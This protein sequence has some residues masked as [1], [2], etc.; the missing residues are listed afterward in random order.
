RLESQRPATARA[1]AASAA[2]NSAGLSGRRAAVQAAPALL[3][4]GLAQLQ[5]PAV[6]GASGRQ[7][8]MAP[9]PSSSHEG[10]LGVRGQIERYRTAFI[11]VVTMIV[12]A[13]A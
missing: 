3:Q 10:G 4:A 1:L 9:Q 5:R 12:I 6:A 13:A 8:L 7:R 2:G 11:A